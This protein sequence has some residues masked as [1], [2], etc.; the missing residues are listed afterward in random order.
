MLI[1]YFLTL[2]ARHFYL[3]LLPNIDFMNTFKLFLFGLLLTSVATFAQVN[4][5]RY[6]GNPIDQ[7]HQSQQP[8]QPSSEEIEEAQTESID[9]YMDKLNKALNLDELQFIAIK[10]EFQSNAKSVNIVMKKEDSQEAKST[11]VK[12]LVDK[13]DANINSYLNKEQRE[14]YEI[15][16]TDMKNGKKDKKDKKNKKKDTSTQE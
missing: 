15:F 11:E 16:K 5:G 2:K 12:A 14:K 3:I 1:I 8:K 6:R 9:K 10:N 13:M 7:F 4:N